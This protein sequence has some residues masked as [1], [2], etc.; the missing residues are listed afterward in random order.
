[1]RWAEERYVKVYT[2]ETPEDVA[3]GWEACAVWWALLRRFDRA[4]ILEMGKT[5]T[6]G[7]AGLLR[8]PVEVVEPAL[9]L[10]VEDGRLRQQGTTLIAL[11]YIATPETP[12]N[13]KAR[14]REKRERDRARAMGG[15]EGHTESQNVTP[16]S[17][18]VTES[19]EPSRAVTPRHSVPCRADPS[20]ADPSRAAPLPPDGGATHATGVPPTESAPDLI[21]LAQTLA[22]EGNGLGKSV[23]ER[24]A[25]GR[26]PTPNQREALRKIRDERAA[27]A[28]PLPPAPSAPKPKARE[29][30]RAEVERM[31]ADA[32]HDRS[33]M[34]PAEGPRVNVVALLGGRAAR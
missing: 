8:I 20:R 5:G 11:N 1:M 14:Q 18:N 21:A 27:G 15:D 34:S 4:G 7:L 28:R 31:L 17:Q 32:E 29:P 9:A 23:V 6:R 2:R 33:T 16:P 22:A 10:L 19:H 24:A 26:L 25:Q 30:T 3:L 13:D 12:Q